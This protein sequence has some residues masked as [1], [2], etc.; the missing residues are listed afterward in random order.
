MGNLFEQFGAGLGVKEIPPAE[1]TGERELDVESEKSEKEN[2]R[3]FS[4]LMLAA[5]KEADEILGEVGG[6]KNGPD[7]QEMEKQAYKIYAA[8]DFLGVEIP[9][10]KGRTAA[11]LV[12]KGTITGFSSEKSAEIFLEEVVYREAA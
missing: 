9:E 4:E 1:E 11:H 7:R 2:D 12:E 6:M 8:L 10:S 5:R 3:E